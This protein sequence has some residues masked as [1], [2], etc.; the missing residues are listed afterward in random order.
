VEERKEERK[1]VGNRIGLS[2]E[3]A[4]GGKEGAKMNR[5]RRKGH[6]TDIVLAYSSNCNPRLS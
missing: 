1:R 2:W 6:A 4:S 5:A 3:G